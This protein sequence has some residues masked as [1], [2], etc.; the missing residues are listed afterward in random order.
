M[1]AKLD[2]PCICQHADFDDDEDLVLL[3][4][5]P[6]TSSPAKVQKAAGGSGSNRAHLLD[7]ASAAACCDCNPSCKALCK[8]S[9]TLLDV[10][11]AAFTYECQYQR[12]FLKYTRRRLLLEAT[13]DTGLVIATQLILNT[14]DVVVALLLMETRTTKKRGHHFVMILSHVS[15]C[16]ITTLDDY[17]SLRSQVQ[18]H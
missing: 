12:P 9:C 2:V 17:P 4:A 18:L 5:N 8:Y 11:V 10:A 3:S 14:D 7:A 16:W 15:S 6:M 13:F 1:V